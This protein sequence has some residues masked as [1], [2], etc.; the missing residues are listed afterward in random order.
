MQTLCR[1]GKT[2]ITFREP[3]QRPAKGPPRFGESGQLITGKAAIKLSVKP[4]AVIDVE[5]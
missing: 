5:S 1:Q 2:G 3:Q 4:W